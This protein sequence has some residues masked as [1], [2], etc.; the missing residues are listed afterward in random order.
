M[1]IQA[2][3]IPEAMPVAMVKRASALNMPEWY[4][5]GSGGGKA[6]RSVCLLLVGLRVTCLVRILESLRSGAFHHCTVRKN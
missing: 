4:L 2:Q 6:N 1:P 5:P 3:V